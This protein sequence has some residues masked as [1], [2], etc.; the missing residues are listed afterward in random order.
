MASPPAGYG[1]R[2]YG[3]RY[4]LGPP[5]AL[6]S[7][8]TPSSH[9]ETYGACEEYGDGMTMAVQFVLVILTYFL[10]IIKLA[11]ICLRIDEND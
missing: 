10:Y 6:L 1:L 8:A 3:P 5:P 4:S 11:G 2:P 7:S 9:D